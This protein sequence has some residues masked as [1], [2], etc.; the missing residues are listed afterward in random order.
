M[1]VI[2]ARN[3]GPTI[4]PLHRNTGKEK[5]RLSNCAIPS[6]YVLS[7]L[8]NPGP[9]D[10]ASAQY[11][12]HPGPAEVDS[13]GTSPRV[14]FSFV[15]QQQMPT[16]AAP[17]RTPRAIV[18]RMEA[19]SSSEQGSVGGWPSFTTI[20]QAVKEAMKKS[21]LGRLC[22]LVRRYALQQCS[23]FKDGRGNFVT[24]EGH[25]HGHD[26]QMWLA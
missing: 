11:S 8:Q 15:R 24:F 1:Q 23:E 2:Q 5:G 21:D 6:S 10:G 18:C 7:C 22:A 3:R 26:E 17:M 16:Q 20:Y 13:R 19:I 12:R 4:P 14:E 25:G 9:R